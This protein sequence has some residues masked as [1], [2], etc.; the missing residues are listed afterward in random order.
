M[1]RWELVRESH[2][3]V[4]AKKSNG[5]G[6]LDR[7]SLVAQSRKTGS[8]Q[9]DKLS[10]HLSLYVIRFFHAVTTEGS[11]S[12]RSS[13][14]SS[15][16]M[17]STKNGRDGSRMVEKSRSFNCYS[18]QCNTCL[19]PLSINKKKKWIKYEKQTV[20]FCEL[21]RPWLHAGVLPIISL[22]LSLPTSERWMRRLRWW[23]IWFITNCN[24]KL[25]EM[26]TIPNNF[27]HYLSI[28]LV[29]RQ[30]AL[31][32][33]ASSMTPSLF[34]FVCSH[35][36]WQGMWWLCWWQAEALLEWWTSCTTKPELFTDGRHFRRE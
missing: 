32:V 26:I 6:P 2:T 33:K 10:F 34:F 16:S 11:Q 23:G 31:T 21:V 25:M 30:Y 13:I 27:S 29:T 22:S 36:A 14:E 12:Y 19:S 20:R 17:T 5:Y 15:S 35:S 3:F 18:I 4:H 8:C 7:I 28:A 9:Q 24:V 1:R